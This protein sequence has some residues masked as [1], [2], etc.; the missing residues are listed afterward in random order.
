MFQLFDDNNQL[1]ESALNDILQ[2]KESIFFEIYR[3]GQDSMGENFRSAFIQKAKEGVKIKIVVDAWG[4]DDNEYFFQPVQDAGVDLRIFHKLIW[5]RGYLSKNHCRNHRKLL[6]IDNKTAYIGSS[7]VTAYSLPWRELNLRLKE[8]TLINIM[9]RSFKDSYHIYNR[10]SF[11]RNYS[12]RD[13]KSGD[14]TFVQ[15]LPN[16]YRQKIKTKYEQMIDKA[17]KQIIIETPYFLPGSVLRKKLKE[18]AQ[19]GVKVVIV[20]PYHSDVH[21]VDIIRRHYLGILHKS[22]VELL[23]YTPGNLHAKCVLIDNEEF[24]IS[25]ANFDYR[26]FR[27]QYELALIGH[28]KQVLK[29]LKQHIDTSL[30]SCQP[31]N[32][33]AWKSRSPIERLIEHILLPFRYLF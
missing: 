25:S 12:K 2:A 28:N 33:K 11:R 9:I 29:L 20:M 32:Y 16:P 19:R 1:F 27:Y 15:D 22:G 4:T 8:P 24:S 3:F 21:A 10:Y 23:F 31:F 6:I 14:W 30:A 17:R 13:V 5:D 26:S 18:A 7:N